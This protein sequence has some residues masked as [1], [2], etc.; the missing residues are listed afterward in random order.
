[1]NI[2]P[3]P[4]RRSCAGFLATL[5]IA[6]SL[7]LTAGANEQP[8]SHL[9]PARGVPSGPR[10]S[11]SLGL[12]LSRASAVL[13]QQL[14]VKRGAGLVVEAVAPESPAAR[15]GF[16]QHD[17]LVKLDDQLLVLPE[18]LDALLAAAEKDVRLDCTI[19]RAGRE[20]SIPLADG[21]VGAASRSPGTA[22][23]GGLRPAASSLALVQQSIARNGPVDAGRLRRLADETLVRQDADY[24]IRLTS[25]DEK[26]L[27]VSDPQG[28]VVFNESIDTPEG[29]SRM[30]TAVQARVAEMERMLEGPSQPVAAAASPPATTPKPAARAE[31]G[32]LDVKPIELR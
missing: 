1:M 18:Q 22:T 9:E 16:A 28:R 7:T 4:C 13:R 26:T 6:G 27:V 12:T 32:S 17:V 10:S 24:Q 21:G 2:T 20:V 19:M 15:A 30:P 8:R 29:R 23:R 11:A 5:A 31:I 14:A 3:P 25:G